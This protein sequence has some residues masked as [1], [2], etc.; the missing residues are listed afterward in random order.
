M[1]G[2]TLNVFSEYGKGSVF[3]FAVR[4]QVMGDEKVGDYQEAFRIATESKAGYK[5]S[6]TAVNARILVVDDTPLNISVFTS[7]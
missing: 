2:S 6:F 3:S 5:Q 1:M 7:L 4:Q